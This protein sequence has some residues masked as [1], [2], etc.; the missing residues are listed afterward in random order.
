MS[1]CVTDQIELSQ[2]S[3]T[4]LKNLVLIAIDR[5]NDCIKQDDAQ[6]YKEAEKF[7]LLADKKLKD[8]P[9]EPEPDWRCPELD[10]PE[11][12]FEVLV[13]AD[14]DVTLAVYRQNQYGQAYFTGIEEVTGWMPK[15]TPKTP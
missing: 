10:P 12:D 2:K 1:S 5:L 9:T 13:C 14:D 15:P 11:V 7:I 4:E 3:N 8:S 6:A